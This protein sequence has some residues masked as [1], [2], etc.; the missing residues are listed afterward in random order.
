MK[1]KKLVII[2]I[3]SLI[4]IVCSVL[5]IN[6]IIST[7]TSEGLT[8]QSSTTNFIITLTSDNKNIDMLKNNLDEGNGIPANLE[9]NIMSL[10]SDNKIRDDT[11]I[12]FKGNLS[13]Q[14]DLKSVNPY[15]EYKDM[16]NRNSFIVIS[17]KSKK[18]FPDNFT[19]K[20][21][22]NIDENK[23]QYDLWGDSHINALK[24][25]PIGNANTIIGYH[26]LSSYINNSDDT[27]FTYDTLVFNE[28]CFKENE[29]CEVNQLN[30]GNK[31][32]NVIQSG[33]ILDNTGKKIGNVTKTNRLKG[34]SMETI[35]INIENTSDITGILMYMGPPIPV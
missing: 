22:N 5:Y 35:L 21:D 23:T 33:D 9:Y 19:I 12:S 1:T 28:N 15:T 7:R 3:L 26:N 2:S 27:L 17:P 24:K 6:Y 8:S 31:I 32:L 14:V 16:S 20:L 18:A 34:V 29:D 10:S 4:V 25:R 30:I 13:Q 11:I